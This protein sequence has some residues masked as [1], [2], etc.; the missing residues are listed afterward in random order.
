MR[1]FIDTRGIESRDCMFKEFLGDLSPNNRM[2]KDVY[3]LIQR[4]GPISKA[5][6]LEK[7]KLKPATLSDKINE[8]LKKN[9]IREYGLGPSTGGRPPILYHIESNCSYIIGIHIL[10]N[11]IKVVLCDLLYSVIEQK[12]FQTTALHTPQ[13]VVLQL[14]GIIHSFLEKYKISF[15]QLLGI[16]IASVGY[17]EQTKGIIVRIDNSFAP[18]WENVHLTEMLTAEFPVRVILEN[19]ADAAVF[20]EFQHMSSQ[21]ENILYCG[22]HEV[23][24]CGVIIEGELIKSKTKNTNIYDHMVIEVNGRQCS[25][26]KRGCLISYTSPYAI[27]KEIKKMY[28]A[29]NEWGKNLEKVHLGDVIEFLKQEDQMTKESVLHSAFYLGVGVSNFINLFDSEFVILDGPLIREYPNYYESVVESIN[30][31][32][33]KGRNVQFRKVTLGNNA[34]AVGAAIYVFQTFVDHNN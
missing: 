27:M 30:K 33:D 24:G 11:E 10:R 8:L 23:I 21:F 29:K 15:N 1:T 25:C 34:I 3:L 6:L 32:L 14:K 22:S 31:H 4:L 20:A 16:G 13:I 9:Y 19:A 7:T 2:L 5:E 12:V 28:A 17:L 18:G 26:G